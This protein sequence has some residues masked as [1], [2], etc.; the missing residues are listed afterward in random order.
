MLLGSI[1]GRG[2]AAAARS[3]EGVFAIFN[4][5]HKTA[6]PKPRGFGPHGGRLESHHGL[7]A[8]WAKAN[9]PGYNPRLAPTVTLERGEGLAHT[10]IT[11]LQEARRQTRIAA[12]LPQYGTTLQEELQF[13]VSDWR[14]AGLSRR[15][16][17]EGLEQQYS[18][19]DEL[20]VSYTRIP[21]PE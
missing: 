4:K 19:L 2:E 10:I 3:E 5:S 18:M 9:I 13:L 17:V 6:M 16:I 14:S 12:K 20:G 8:A 1:L 15:Q 11:D 7:Q 21:V